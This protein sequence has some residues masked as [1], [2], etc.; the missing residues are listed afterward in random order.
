M[1]I[2]NAGEMTIKDLET[3]IKY[4]TAL[5][6]IEKGSD[7]DL[8]VDVQSCNALLTVYDALKE[9]NNKEKFKKQLQKMQTLERLLKFS[10]DKVAT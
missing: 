7:N 2:R 6:V 1:F 8:I 3:A 4:H 10:W 5:L 9:E